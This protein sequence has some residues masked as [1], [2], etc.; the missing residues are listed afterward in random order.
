MDK[1]KTI[2]RENIEIRGQQY[3]DVYYLLNED[4][5]HDILRSSEVLS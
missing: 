3:Q 5:K 2:R 1:L 4:T